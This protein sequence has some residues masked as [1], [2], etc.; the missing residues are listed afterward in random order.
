MHTFKLTKAKKMK[1]LFPLLVLTLMIAQLSYAEVSRKEKKALLE[2]YEHTNGKHWVKKWDITQPVGQWYGVEVVDNK[3]VGLQLFRNNVMGVLPN[4]IGDLENLEILNLAFNS[5]TGEFP[6]TLAKL[7]KLKVL[8]LEMNRMKGEL[9]ANM[10]DMSSLEEFS[11]FNNFI[12]GSIPES[13]GNIKSLKIL[14]LSSNNFKGSIP[15][16]LSDL[17]NL[18]TLGLFENNLEGAIPIAM[19]S[20]K[21][22]KELVLANNALDGEI[23]AGF[24]QLASLR[25][26]Q[27]QN[28]KFTSFKNL[29]LLNEREFLVFDYDREDRKIQFKDINFSKSRMAD[30]KFEDIE[31]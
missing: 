23:P 15:S 25:V 30:T 11:I 31:E 26:F 18:E 12:T 21:N 10:G 2:F 17:A 29:E 6:Q 14:N 20:L 5:I 28:N 9:P 16:T 24:E 8:K 4:A 7:T 3:V 13:V 19:G 1:K 27:I 22:L